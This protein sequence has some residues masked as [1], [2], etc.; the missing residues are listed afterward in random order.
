[1][2]GKTSEK[3]ANDIK[4]AIIDIEKSLNEKDRYKTKILQSAIDT[5]KMQQE[6]KFLE[7]TGK[8]D[9]QLKDKDIQIQ[10][11]EARISKLE[12]EIDLLKI[13]HK[14]IENQETIASQHSSKEI[15]NVVPPN[16][17]NKI[18]LSK[19]TNNVTNQDENSHSQPALKNEQRLEIV[20]TSSPTISLEA[21][22]LACKLFKT[23]LNHLLDSGITKFFCSP[24][25]QATYQE[26]FCVIRERI[27]KDS[28][29]ISEKFLL[30]KSKCTDPKKLYKVYSFNQ[31][32]NG[33]QFIDLNI[34]EKGWRHE[35]TEVSIL[36]PYS[37]N[38]AIQMNQSNK[39]DYF[40]QWEI[41]LIP[42]EYI[43]KDGYFIVFCLK[44]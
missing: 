20:T 12:N 43:G 5:M 33:D 7:V 23:E 44:K 36:H 40:H 25:L 29:V 21:L 37:I 17:T 14:D 24:D 10:G 4:D 15:D 2:A 27:T 28:P 3:C 38:K 8:K 31:D 9:L 39:R 41:N 35:N 42:N 1:M 26:W 34:F 13:R 30:A 6:L 11:K 16:E 18:K 19:V 22:E 32:R